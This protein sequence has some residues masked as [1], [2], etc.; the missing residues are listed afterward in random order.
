MRL[1][2]TYMLELVVKCATNCDAAETEA[3]DAGYRVRADF[4][5]Y[6]IDGDRSRVRVQLTVTATRPKDAE[7]LPY[8]RVKV[9]LCGDFSRGSDAD[10]ETFLRLVPMNCLAILHGIARGVLLSATATCPSGP[11]LLPTVNYVDLV[12]RKVKALRRKSSR[13]ARDS[14]ATEE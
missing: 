14:D 9:V 1:D 12:D 11:F 10:E 7:H 3:L 6:G 13:K 4:D 5:L 8:E 2:G